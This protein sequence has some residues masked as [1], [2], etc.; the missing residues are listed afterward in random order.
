MGI[1]GAW[2]RLQAFFHHGFSVRATKMLRAAPPR[3]PAAGAKGIAID[4]AMWKNH[5]RREIERKGV[6]A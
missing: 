4:P 5:V 3:G 6:A 2:N 1:L